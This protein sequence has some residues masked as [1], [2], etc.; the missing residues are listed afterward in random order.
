MGR[1]MAALRSM[2]GDD[3]VFFG[4]GVKWQAEVVC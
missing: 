2:G 4:V 1:D 3:W